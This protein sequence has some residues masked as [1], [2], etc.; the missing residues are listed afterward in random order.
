MRSLLA[1]LAVC[2]V[3][4]VAVPAGASPGSGQATIF[5]V[6]QP[7]AGANA[8]FGDCP[9]IASLPPVGT[10][11]RESFVVF[12]RETGVLGGGSVAPSNAHWT[13]FATTYT[14]TFAVPDADPLVSD[15][16]EGSL[17]DPV[18]SSDDQRVSFAAVAA[19]VP[20]SDGST[21]DFRGTWS[22]YGERWVFGSNGPLNIGNGVPRH[23]VDK[24]TTSNAN[25]HQTGRFAKMNGTL[26]GQPVHSYTFVDEAGS[27]FYNHFV[28]VDVTHG[29][30][31]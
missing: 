22:G 10:V 8:N 3:V 20:M 1:A 18:A 6:K 30:C 29:G 21:F 27:I 25:A 11:C 4:A 23:Y 17:V 31:P 9:D 15:V 13:I 2:A 26:N 5:R 12:F 16:I 24:C 7:S 14:L 19:M 28:Y